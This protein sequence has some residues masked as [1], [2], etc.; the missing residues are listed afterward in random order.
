[1]QHAMSVTTAWQI[2]AFELGRQLVCS[3][4][5][6]DMRD[7]YVDW[8]LLHTWRLLCTSVWQDTMASFHCTLG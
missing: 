8:A 6:L 5:D 7:M 2:T 1:M 4:V 3:H